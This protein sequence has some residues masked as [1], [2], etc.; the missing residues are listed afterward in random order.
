M[1]IRIDN[2]SYT[3]PAGTR[4]LNNISLEIAAGERV[5]ITGH[6]GSGK[7]TLVKHLNGLLKPENGDVWINEANTRSCQT[8]LLAHEVALLFQNPDDQICKQT[9]QAEIA[10]GPKNLGF[11]KEKVNNLVEEALTLFDLNGY[12]E[13]NPHDLGY[14]ERK[15]TAMASIV[16]MD[17]SILIFDE[18]TA[19]LDQH[20]MAILLQVFEKLQQ[21][22]K[23]LIIISHDIDFIAE[24]IARV[25]SLTQGE[26]IFDGDIKTLFQDDTVLSRCGLMPPQMVRLCRSCSLSVPALTPEEFISVYAQKKIESLATLKKQF[27][28]KQDPVEAA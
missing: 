10:F 22:N 18:P 19:G 4:A 2:I 17:T 21:K 9:V 16:A 7:S 12:R 14:S 15:R 1:T 27:N 26:K 6:N 24:N 11:R 23:T 13:V 8:N 28:Q 5:A 20:E 25:I 3:Y